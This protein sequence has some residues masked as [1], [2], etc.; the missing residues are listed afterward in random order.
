MATEIVEYRP[1]KWAK[2]VDGRIVGRATPAEVA[3][4]QQAARAQSPASL[5][6]DLDIDLSPEPAAD[7]ARVRDVSRRPAFERRGRH[8]ASASSR[9]HSARPSA[10]DAAPAAPPGD[11]PARQAK[12]RPASAKP[13]APPGDAK[14][15]KA[16]PASAKPAQPSPPPV[17]RPERARQASPPPNPPAAGATVAEEAEAPPARSSERSPGYWWVWNARNQPVAAF[18]KEWGP[19]YKAKFGRE[20]TLI[21]CHADDLAAVEACGYSAQVNPLL[22]RGHFYLGQSDID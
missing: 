18:L 14:R 5:D 19:K 6:I 12:A 3:A 8:V 9:S 2:V 17:K 20:A 4:W 11:A 10:G 13:A 16:R 15:S 7:P 21:L 22:E 1:G